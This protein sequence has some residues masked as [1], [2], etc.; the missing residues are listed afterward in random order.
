[1]IAP[2]PLRLAPILKP[3]VW[4]GRRLARLGK[5]L[6]EGVAIGE[7]WELA[8]LEASSPDGG[9]GG[10]ER[11]RIANGPLVARTLADVIRL[12]GAD[13]LGSLP[14]PGGFPLLV[15]FLDADEPLSVQVHPSPEYAASHPGCHVK[16][17]CWLVL[18]AD[19]GAVLYKGL[20]SGTTVDDLAGA[21]RDGRIVECLERV[22]AIVGEC[23]DLPSGTV[24][25]LGAGI[26][27][28]E[29]Q[30]PSD[31]TFRLWDWPELGRSGRALHVAEGLASAR[32]EPTPAV[33]RAEPTSRSTPLASTIAYDL[34]ELRVDAGEPVE[35]PVRRRAPQ[36]V[37]V[38]EGSVDADGHPLSHGD[39]VL[40]PAACDPAALLA[41]TPTRALAVG[42]PLAA[43]VR[44]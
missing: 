37:I 34:W 6:P 2:Y 12:W 16:S 1:M 10:P 31:T 40:V 39:T 44:R 27:V 21:V 18:H 36:V 20:R 30:T 5:T 14:A 23:H 4:G 7:S 19:P 43:T 8:D 22:P 41:R 29:V 32:T 33:T 9:G 17:E 3:K 13:L 15:K 11:S 35:H 26:V 24:H 42:F 28:A 38:L 25:A